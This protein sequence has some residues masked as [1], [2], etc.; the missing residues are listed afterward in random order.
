[1]IRLDDIRKSYGNLEVLRGVSL[2]VPDGEIMT[3]V[4]PSGAGKTTL[5]QICGTL[6]RPGSGTVSYDGV[7]T[8]RLSERRLADFRCRN[9]GF[10]F[11]FHELLPE[12]T[13]LENAS[14]PAQ[15]AGLRRREAFA[16]GEELLV[17]LGL[18]DR[19]RHR[20]SELSGGE[21]QR[22]PIARALVNDP[23]VVL[24]DEPTGSLDS[25]NREQIKRLIA[26]LCAERRQTFL[27]V[28][29]DATL[30]DISHSV[31]TMADG[32]IVDLQS[33]SPQPL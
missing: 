12:F 33:R 19:L 20:P 9:V 5:L 11:Q 22:V 28:T 18:G 1:M 3:I 32:R 4:G 14:L 27:I 29:H 30:C 24:A 6:D 16:K 31:V 21:K 13:A 10:V 23:A 17:R 7:E 8:F 26:E 25:A 15:I 2:E